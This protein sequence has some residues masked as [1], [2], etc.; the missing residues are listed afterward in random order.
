MMG[1][2]SSLRR[3]QKVRL[4]FQPIHTANGRT[5]NDRLSKIGIQATKW[6]SHAQRVRP[7]GHCLYPLCTITRFLPAR[8]AAYKASSANSTS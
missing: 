4:S 5:T 2:V 1:F 8:L 3:T 7:A 6:Q